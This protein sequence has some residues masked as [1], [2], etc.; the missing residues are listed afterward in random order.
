M[1]SETYDQLRRALLQVLGPKPSPERRR[2]IASDLRALAEQQERMAARDEQP[3]A[4]Q[5]PGRTRHPVPQ[6]DPNRTAGMYVRISHEPDRITGERRV[7]LSIGRQVWYDLGSPERIT[8]QRTGTEI[9][10]EPTT[11]RAAYQLQSGSLPTCILAANDPLAALAPGR[12]AASI[13]AG[14]IVVGQKVA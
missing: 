12:Y 2:Q 11:A 5:S 7:R 8:V 14:A 6:E 4:A 3:S 9:W 10:I 1:T 13:R